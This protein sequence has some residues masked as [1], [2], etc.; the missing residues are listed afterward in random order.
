MVS[1]Y[2]AVMQGRDQVLRDAAEP[3]PAGGDGH[4]VVEQAVESRLCIGVNFAHVE[5]A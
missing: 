3:E 2:A 1:L 5:E 4:V